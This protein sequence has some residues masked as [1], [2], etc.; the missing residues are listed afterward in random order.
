MDQEGL[1]DFVGRSDDLFG[2]AKIALCC[3]EDDLSSRYIGL[4]YAYRLLAAG[5]MAASTKR[6]RRLVDCPDITELI[7]WWDKRE[8]QE[9]PRICDACGME[10]GHGGF[11]GRKGKKAE[12]RDCHGAT[13]CSIACKAEHYPI[14]RPA[15]LIL[16]GL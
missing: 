12:C 13:W 5:P 7:N 14:H 2:A 15:C 11:E 1:Y 10:E 4:S 9:L 8:S 6:L 3:N 16:R